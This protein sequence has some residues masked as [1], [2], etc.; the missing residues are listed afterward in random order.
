MQLLAR[1]S[2]LAATFTMLACQGDRSIGVPPHR[3][4]PMS[5]L[6][7]LEPARVLVEARVDPKAILGGPIIGLGG[8]ILGEVKLLE[9]PAAVLK[10]LIESEL[11]SA[12]HELAPAPESASLEITVETFRLTTDRNDLFDNLT[13]EISVLVAPT[14]SRYSGA[15]QLR[16]DAYP[17]SN[18]LSALAQRCLAQIASQFRQ[19]A[20]IHDWLRSH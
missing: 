10:A 20:R 16:N 9:D 4:E 11:A 19:D 18:D 3:P 17:R 1:F 8:E 5:P 12:G 13:I 2:V 7:E 6:A 14:D 15:A